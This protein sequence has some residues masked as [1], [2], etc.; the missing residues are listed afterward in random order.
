M[1]GGSGG[2][3]EDNLINLD[4]DATLYEL[5]GVTPDCD[6]TTLRAPTEAGPA[7]APDKCTE[8]DAEQTFKRI[9]SAFQIYPT[10]RA[11]MT[12]SSPATTTT[13]PHAHEALR[14][15]DEA[16]AQAWQEFLWAEEQGGSRRLARC[17]CWYG[18]LSLVVWGGLLLLLLRMV[19]PANSALLFPPPS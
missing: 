17:W 10:R 9:S 16:A 12:M 6:D 1:P 7:V 3:D 14:H 5:L 13:R 4:E 8:P 19:A 2:T 11:G 18:M 15:A